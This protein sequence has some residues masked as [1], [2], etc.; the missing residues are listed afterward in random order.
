MNIKKIIEINRKMR[1][2]S[3]DVGIHHLS[4][5]ILDQDDETKK[6]TIKN[7]GLIDLVDTVEQKKNVTLIY[8]NIPRKLDEKPEL[9][10]NIDRVCI[11]NQPTLKNPTMKTIQ[12]ILFSY[13]LIRGKCDNKEHP[14]GLISFISAT[15]KLKVYNG[16]PID[17]DLYTKSGNLKKIPKSKSKDKN[18]PLIIDFLE[19]TKE[20][21]QQQVEVKEEVKEDEVKKTPT[22]C[23]GDKKKLAILYTR[24]IIKKD[25]SHYLTFFEENKKKDDLS[26]SFLQGVYVLTQKEI[27]QQRLEE[28]KKINADKP[29]KPRKKKITVLDSLLEEDKT[30]VK[31]KRT[32]KKKDEVK[33]EIKVDDNK[34]PKKKLTKKELERLK[35]DAYRSDSS[36]EN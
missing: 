25:H 21:L 36:E 11:E 7:W 22:I 30:E 18:Q 14:I 13:F 27:Q 2:L 19:E 26:D 31:V 9:L 32:R 15:N 1:L 5:C 8:D 16:P 3:W 35:E 4:Y 29:K 28:K 17:P 23:Y 34:K 6:I 20:D 24:E 10:D 12:I 33:E